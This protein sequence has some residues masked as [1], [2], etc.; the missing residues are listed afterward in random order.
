MV[1]G[2][3]MLGRHFIKDKHMIIFQFQLPKVK[4]MLLFQTELE[5]VDNWI[6]S[7]TCH[8]KVAKS[9]KNLGKLGY[10]CKGTCYF[11]HF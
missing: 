5:R 8:S 4:G 2:G 10:R 11:N 7:I 1:G 6:R 9:V 3:G